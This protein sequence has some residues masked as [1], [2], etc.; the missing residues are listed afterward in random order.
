[1]QSPNPKRDGPGV[2]EALPQALGVIRDR[3]GCE[4]VDRLWLFP[5]LVK[6]RSERGLVVASCFHYGDETAEEGE[7][8][9][10]RRLLHTLTYQAEQ[11]GRGG[12]SVEAELFEEG[13]APEELLPSVIRGVVRRTEVE[14]GDPRSVQIGGDAVEFNKLLDELEPAPLKA[15]LS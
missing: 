2:P 7:A 12:L 14:L 11:T 8:E 3:L 6:G 1:M 13:L 10:D 4:K 9:A 5:P 15:A